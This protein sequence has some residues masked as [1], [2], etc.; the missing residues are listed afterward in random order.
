MAPFARS[1]NVKEKRSKSALRAKQTCSSG[2]GPACERAH[3][4]GECFLQSGSS[5]CHGNALSSKGSFKM[6]YGD[7]GLLM[8]KIFHYKRKK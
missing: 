2:S 6:F 5:F 8:R 7:E 3:G 4:M 1:S